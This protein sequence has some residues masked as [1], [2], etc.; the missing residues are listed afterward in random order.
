MTN[1]ELNDLRSEFVEGVKGFGRIIIILF[2]SVGFLG[3]GMLKL[4]GMPEMASEFARWKLPSWSLYAI[5]FL[6]VILAVLLF[7]VPTRKTACKVVMLFMLIVATFHAYLG[8][9]DRLLAP[10][11]LLAAAF[12]LLFVESSTDQN[13]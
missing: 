13:K 2:L 7:Y 3:V 5:G 6:E 8:E 12:L 9:Y 4:V 1:P 11:I 10:S